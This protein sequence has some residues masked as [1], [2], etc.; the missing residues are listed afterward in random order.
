ML[1]SVLWRDAVLVSMCVLGI[2]QMLFLASAWCDRC[3]T[4]ALNCIHWFLCI[5]REIWLQ[6]S[7]TNQNQKLKYLARAVRIDA[8]D[9]V[10]D[11]SVYGKNFVTLLSVPTVWDSESSFILK[12]S[13]CS[14]FLRFSSS[15]RTWKGET[16]TYHTLQA[17]H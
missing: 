1:V 13:S 17:S 3:F 6:K 5:Y 2:S 14:F 16:T 9:H 11:E 15:S 12:K 8:G 10:V 7:V 4:A